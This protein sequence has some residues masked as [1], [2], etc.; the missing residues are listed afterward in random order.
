M[1]LSSIQCL[2]SGDDDKVITKRF[3]LPDLDLPRSI[4]PLPPIFLGPDLDTPLS[5]RH[6]RPILDLCPRIRLV[7]QN[8]DLPILDKRWV[9]GIPN[10]LGPLGLSEG[11]IGLRKA[12]EE[13][14]SDVV[15]G[16]IVVECWTG[17]GA[18]SIM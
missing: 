8:V 13:S 3:R 16:R 18:G 11:S 9:I 7:Q 10:K 14:V 12:G 17:R 4:L 5:V 2:T 6:A 15:A 1:R